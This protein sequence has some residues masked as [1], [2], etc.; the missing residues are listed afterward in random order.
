MTTWSYWALFV[1]A[2]LLLLVVIPQ[3][4]REAELR[5]DEIDKEDW[6]DFQRGIRW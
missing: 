5:Q 6:E 2:I 1:V 3:L 4:I